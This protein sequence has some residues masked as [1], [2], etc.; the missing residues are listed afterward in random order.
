MKKFKAN[1]GFKQSMSDYSTSYPTSFESHNPAIFSKK[2]KKSKKNRD[3]VVFDE[4]NQTRTLDQI[5]NNIPKK[6]ANEEN[7]IQ[8]NHNDKLFLER[9]IGNRLNVDNDDEDYAINSAHPKF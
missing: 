8:I 2:N 6:S 9:Y 1:N 7:I 5:I 3:F 4:P